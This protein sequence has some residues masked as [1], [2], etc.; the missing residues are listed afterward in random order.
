MSRLAPASSTASGIRCR[1]APPI[2]PP[3]E[4]ATKTSVTLFNNSCRKKKVRIP[5]K[6]IILTTKVATTICIKVIKLESPPDP[7]YLNKF[8][9]TFWQ[10]RQRP[11]NSS[12]WSS[13]LNP[14]LLAKLCSSS[15]RLWLAKSI[16]VPQLEQIKWWWWPGAP[17]V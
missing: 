13:I 10:A 2:R 15:P 8:Y 5:T 7:S 4:S 16:T 17:V 11:T 9:V 1:K 6:A 14:L 3:A 12:R